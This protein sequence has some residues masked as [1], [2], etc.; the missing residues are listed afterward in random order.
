MVALTLHPSREALADAHHERL[1]A[2]RAGEV[3]NVHSWELVTAVDGP[4][5]RLTVFLNGCPLR[6]RYCHNPDTW[7]LRDGTATT[8]DELVTRIARYRDIFAATGGGLTLSGGEPLMQ[9]PFV[10]RVLHEASALGVRTALD[11]SGFLGQK[12][13]DAMLDDVDLVLL[14]VKSGL[15]ETY[16]DVTGVDLEPTIAFGDRLAARGARVW[17]RFVLVPGL[18]DAD[19]NVD[20]VARI[21]SRWPNVER[22]EVLPFHQMGADK[23]ERIGATYSLADT[24]LPEP[25][26]VDAVRDRFRRAGVPVA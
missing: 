25:A 1:R 16:R 26:Q 23:W 19:E 8:V 9:A 17:V 11:T 14:D 22:L 12:A 13:D 15:P 20:A 6:C 5:T 21:V 24:R 10:R 3:G 7:R 4:G 2:Q 18:T